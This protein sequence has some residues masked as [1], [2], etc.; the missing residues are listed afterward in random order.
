MIDLLRVFEETR[1]RGIGP[2]LIASTGDIDELVA[3]LDAAFA[4]I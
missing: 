3:A 4:T 2:P 1:K